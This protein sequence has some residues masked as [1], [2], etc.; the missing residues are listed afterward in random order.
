MKPPK[1]SAVL[2]V[3]GVLGNTIDA[4]LPILNGISSK[5][6]KH[7]DIDQY[8]M[9]AV[10]G[11]TPDQTRLF[12]EHTWHSHTFCSTIEPYPHA[13]AGVEMLRIADFE[14]FVATAPM[15]EVIYWYAQREKWLAKH[16]GIPS[17]RVIH[18]SGEG[19]ALLGCNF[20]FEDKTSTLI[21]WED[22]ND[23]LNG[24]H[25]IRIAR[26]YNAKEPYGDRGYNGTTVNNMIEGA[27]RAIS[28]WHGWYK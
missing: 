25:G 9:E 23:N 2:D 16:F 3:D 1:P 8:F 7:D 26:A 22:A 6:L 27:E 12:H 18:A 20:L 28:L 19:K 17:S 21:G 14:L 5:Q 10:A 4:A 24:F 11:L 13:Q 15:P